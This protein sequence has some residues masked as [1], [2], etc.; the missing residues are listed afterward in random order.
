MTDL[1]LAAIIREEVYTAVHRE[2]RGVRVHGQA[3]GR[4]R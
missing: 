1:S 2:V 4:I 3:A